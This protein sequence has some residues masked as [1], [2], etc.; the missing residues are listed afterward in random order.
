MLRLRNHSKRARL[1]WTVLSLAVLAVAAASAGPLQE[2]AKPYDKYLGKYEFDLSGMGGGVRVFEFYVKDNGFWI[3]YGFTSP[4]RLE[5]VSGV[6][7]QFTFDDPDDGPSTVTFLKDN[8][9]RYDRVRLVNTAVGID[10]I[11]TKQK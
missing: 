1:P 5:P 4:G 9:G 8:S 2:T 3:E 11:G 10:I 7:D 6:A